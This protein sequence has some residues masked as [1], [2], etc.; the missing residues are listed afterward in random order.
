MMNVFMLQLMCVLMQ[1]Q[2]YSVMY[3]AAFKK[4]FMD[5]ELLHHKLS[6]SVSLLDTTNLD[7]NEE[8]VD[9]MPEDQ[10]AS[11]DTLMVLLTLLS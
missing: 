1:S 5:V 2:V 7:L 4:L 10:T 8:E 9:N 3:T 11:A 6:L